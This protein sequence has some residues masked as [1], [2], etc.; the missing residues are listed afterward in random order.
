MRF[1][2]LLWLFLAIAHH[3]VGY[4][5]PLP[6]IYPENIETF[7]KLK[8]GSILNL[9]CGLNYNAYSILL[10]PNFDTPN[11][12]Q[13]RMMMLPLPIFKWN[14]PQ[15]VSENDQR[16]SISP[17]RHI[18]LYGKLERAVSTIKIIDLV[19]SDSGMYGC[20]VEFKENPNL[21][22]DNSLTVKVV[23]DEWI[24]LENIAQRN[25]KYLALNAP[26]I[27]PDT[28]ST[29]TVGDQLNVTCV[30]QYTSQKPT[31]VWKVPLGKSKNPRMRAKNSIVMS[32]GL[33]R[34]IISTM[35]IDNVQVE[36]SG[37]YICFV[38]QFPKTRS[39]Q[40]KLKLTVEGF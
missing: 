17:A 10:D 27:Y 30:V 32:G 14:L 6:E 11:P 20:S 1:I 33:S 15:G 21:K 34:K 39:K 37:S 5:L 2:L 12:R 9:I 35:V 7:D 19:E 8:T 16:V 36:D 40:S 13:K 18:G 26:K 29:L 28:T 38:K 25:E 23:N 22:S 24:G 31:I 3:V 4:D